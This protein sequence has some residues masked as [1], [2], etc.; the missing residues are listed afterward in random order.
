[1]ENKFSHLDARGKGELDYDLKQDILFFKVKDREYVKSIELDNIVID[2]DSEQFITGIQIFEASKFLR[3]D[4]AFLTKMP[5]WEFN[6][7]IKDNKVEL[8]LTFTVV[9]RNK[10]IEKISPII[11]EKVEDSLPNSEMLLSVAK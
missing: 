7:T 9:A 5:T 6:A 8:R 10:I 11:I 1:M 2:I 3:I 4:K